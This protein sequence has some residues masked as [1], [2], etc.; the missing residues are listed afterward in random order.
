MPAKERKHICSGGLL[1]LR[2]CLPSIHYP[3]KLLM[4]LYICCAKCWYLIRWVVYFFTSLTQFES[5]WWRQS[6]YVVLLVNDCNC[7]VSYANV[8]WLTAVP[9]F[10][11]FT[12]FDI[13]RINEYRWLMHWH[14][15]TWTKVDCDIT[16]AC[17]NVVTRLQ[18]VCDNIPRSSKALL[19]KPSTT[20]GSEKWPRCNKLKVNLLFSIIFRKL[21]IFF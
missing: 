13:F 7:N 2:V 9:L 20:I 3:L 17:V 15:P 19:H 1:N 21:T 4:K 8:E 16:R 11:I 18:V 6:D 5:V 14:I 10:S 12:K